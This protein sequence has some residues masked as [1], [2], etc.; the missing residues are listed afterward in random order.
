MRQVISSIIIDE[1]KYKLN[2]TEILWIIILLAFSLSLFGVPNYIFLL[3]C[4]VYFLNIIKKKAFFKFNINIIIIFLFS[5]TYYLIYIRYYSASFDNMLKYLVG[6]IAFY[7]MGHTIIRTNQNF[8]MYSILSIS[9]GN[10]LHGFMNMA[11]HF[12]QNGFVLLIRR[13]PDI[14]TGELIAATLQ[15]TFFTLQ[16]SLFFY[17]LFYFRGKGHKFIKIFYLATVVFS[18]YTSFLLGNRT[19]PLMFL[20]IVIIN[21]L[22]HSR[23]TNFKSK[24]KLTISM[25]LSLTIIFLVI[26]SNSF[27]IYDFILNSELFYRFSEN[28]IINDPRIQVY[29]QVYNQFWDYPFGGNQM[30]LGLTYAHNLWLDVLNTTG[31][32]PFMFLQYFTILTF[33]DIF[34]LYKSKQASMKLKVFSISIYTG[35]ILNFLVEPIL[36]GKPYM[37]LTFCLFVG[38]LNKIIIVCKRDELNRRNKVN[39]VTI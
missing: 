15:G 38:M 10:F 16:I 26:K 11:K 35:F 29:T 24:L 32:I 17:F 39:E 3:L 1:Q 14:W 6:P 36:E 9:I 28:S 20:I 34:K 23:L 7:F 8:F 37:F 5:I 2:I 13:V 19:L 22:V 27:G 33:L 25:F 18:I 30:N 21:L 4:F 31:I 12:E